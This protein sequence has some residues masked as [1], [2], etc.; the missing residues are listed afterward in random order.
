M[1]SH[2]N[3]P[4]QTRVLRSESFR[5]TYVTKSGKTET[6]RFSNSI[7]T[8]F[9]NGLQNPDNDYQLEVPEDHEDRDDFYI[10]TDP[11]GVKEHFNVRGQILFRE[12]PNGKRT[13]FEYNDF[14][15]LT[16]LDTVT[17]HYGHSIKFDYELIPL[18]GFNS[19][20][21]YT[22]ETSVGNNGGGTR[23]FLVET[24]YQRLR[25][26]TDPFGAEYRYQ[27]DDNHNLVEVIYPDTTPDDSDNPRKTYHYENENFP[28]H[29]TGITDE[30]GERY[31][32]FSYDEDGRAIVSELGVTTN[33]VGQE[34][35]ELDYQGTN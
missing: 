4:Y 10:V 11:N 7:T 5:A 23:T 35:I 12:D 24:P 32:N 30:N 25:K 16:Y 27:Y 31:A 2:W 1:G 15:G 18:D 6:F 20:D 34:K 8:Q 33:Q 26:V 14:F 19:I 3:H 9:E 28:N 17:D 29:L 21:D 22:A 13:T